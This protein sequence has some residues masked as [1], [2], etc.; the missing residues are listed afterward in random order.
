MPHPK[1]RIN[2]CFQDGDSVTVMLKN[3]IR[4]QTEEEAEWYEKAFGKKR[5]MMRVSFLYKP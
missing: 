4:D 5:N 2:Q 3:R 1:K